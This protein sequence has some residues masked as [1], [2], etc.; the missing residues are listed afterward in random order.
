MLFHWQWLFYQG[1]QPHEHWVLSNGCASQFKGAHAIFFVARY[2]TLTNGCK[3][4]WQYF[5]TSHGKGMHM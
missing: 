3:M 1:V 4:R 5:G 2:P